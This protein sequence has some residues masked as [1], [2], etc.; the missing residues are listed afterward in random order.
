MV[1]FERHAQ[2][3]TE[4]WNDQ[5][6]AEGCCA[7]APEID[8]PITRHWAEFSKSLEAGSHI[9]DLACGNGAAGRALIA[10]NPS[11][12]VTG[13]DFAVVPA[14]REPQIEIL[15]GIEMEQLPFA[16]GSFDAAVSQF[17]FE[18]GAVALASAEL[19]R[20]LRP[21]APFSLLVH[22]AEG[23]IAK[24]SIIHRQALQSITGAAIEAAFLSGDGAKLDQQ[25][26]DLGRQCRYERIVAEAGNGLRQ[27]IGLSAGHRAEIWRAVR[28]ALEPELVMLADLDAAAVSREALSN[29]LARLD[30]GLDLR[31]TMELQMSSGQTL[32]WKMVGV[33]RAN[34][35]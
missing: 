16:D 1:A 33:R 9:V 15:P 6:E 13:I 2:A 17:G 30:G 32:C 27:L 11:L 18:Y 4:F 23:R 28:V 35:H 14:S 25:L 19:A 10:A 12:C 5:N 26:A 8:R 7:N 34:L 31:R 29:W 3:W 24:D 21:N 20:V 22:H